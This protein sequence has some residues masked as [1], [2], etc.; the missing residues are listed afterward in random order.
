MTTDE[1]AIRDLVA[2]WMD[3]SMRGDLPTV[4]SLMAEDVVFLVAGQSPMRGREAFAAASQGMAASGMKIEGRS[5]IQEIQTVG[6]FAYCWNHLTITVT[7]PSGEPM[8]RSGPALS[9][10]RKGADGKWV[11]VRDAN[12]VTREQ[13]R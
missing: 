6:D 1:Q 12:M 7:L 4:L 10:L 13:A 9:I 3:A 5:D 2:T 11:I 8:R